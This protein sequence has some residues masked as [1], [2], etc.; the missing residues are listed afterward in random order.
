LKLELE[1]FLSSI[2]ENRNP[3]VGGKEALD[4]LKVALKAEG[5]Q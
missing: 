2:A 1:D 4:I 5:A 3:A